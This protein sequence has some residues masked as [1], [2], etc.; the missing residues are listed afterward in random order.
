MPCDDWPVVDVRDKS[1]NFDIISGIH[2]LKLR[3]LLMC[4]PSAWILGCHLTAKAMA[5]WPESSSISGDQSHRDYSIQRSNI[6][7][8]MS[9]ICKDVPQANVFVYLCISFMHEHDNP[10]MHTVLSSLTGLMRMPHLLKKSLNH[11][12]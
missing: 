6:P 4:H 11:S 7:Q 2:F 5:T 9:H 10:S 1:G 8:R 3:H 12:P